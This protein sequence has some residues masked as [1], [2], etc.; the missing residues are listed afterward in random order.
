[1]FRQQIKDRNRILEDD[2]VNSIL[3]IGD[4]D[5][6]KNI[7]LWRRIYR[8]IWITILEA[9]WLWVFNNDDT[10]SIKIQVFDKE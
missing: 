2:D 1:M 6:I 9:E 4:G 7:S 10:W 8:R 5:M 3:N